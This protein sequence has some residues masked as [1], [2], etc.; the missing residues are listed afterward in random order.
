MNK[1]AILGIILVIIVGGGIAYKVF[2]GSSQA[3]IE[4]GVVKEI[5][6]VSKRLEWKFEPETI[7]VEQGDKVKLKVIN[8]DNFDHGVAIDAFGISQRLPASGSIDIEFVASKSGVFPFYCSVSCS[9][10]D[11]GTFDL[12]N[13]EVQTGPYTGTVRGHFEHI[14]QFV[15]RALQTMGMMDE[16]D[17]HAHDDSHNHQ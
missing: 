5:T 2:I 7:E 1:F 16:E 8:E 14:G 10:S 3:P 9:S 6:V 4:T 13:G 15:V 17:G 12:P 11:A